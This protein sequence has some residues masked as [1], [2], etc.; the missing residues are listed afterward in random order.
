MAA[1]TVAALDKHLV[2][3]GLSRYLRLFDPGTFEPT[4]SSNDEPMDRNEMMNSE[5]SGDVLEC[6]VGGYLVRARRTDAWE[7][8]RLRTQFRELFASQSDPVNIRPL[9]AVS[10][11]E[12]RSILSAGASGAHGTSAVAFC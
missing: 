11:C 8:G 9:H 2:I 1:R 4:V 6:E 5:T 3:V 10:G 7:D 12:C